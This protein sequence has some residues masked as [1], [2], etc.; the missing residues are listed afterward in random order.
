M[1]RLLAG[2]AVLP[3]LVSLTVL[4]GAPAAHADDRVCR[5]TIGATSTDD[6]IVVPKGATCRLLRTTVGGNVIVKRGAKLV[7][8]GARIDGN[9]Q[10]EKA[11]RVVVRKIDGR[12][13]VV[14]GNIQLDDGRRGGV[15]R[16]AVVDGD[17][18]L[19]GNRGRF[20]VRG[21]RVDGNL[22]CKGNKPRPRGGNNK[23][24]G[25]KEDQCKRL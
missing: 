10:A 12:R 16:R 15:I 21:N 17:I 8:R 3:L 23:V 20:V 25:N 24:S 14:E 5:G 11:K 19:F 18:Q 22:Q 13:T 6:N 9:I 1:K 2:A 7:A 4:G